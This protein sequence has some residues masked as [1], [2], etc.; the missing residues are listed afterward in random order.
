MEAYYCAVSL[1]LF[2]MAIL[3]FVLAIREVFPFLNPK[4]QNS[5]RV[6]FSGGD[7]RRWRTRDL[8]IKNAW[9]EHARLFPKS[10]KRVVFAVFLIGAALSLLGYPLWQAFG[11]R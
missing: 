5:I 9:N 7:F 2:C 3:A 6:Y 1:P 8:A 4:D 11:P 10:R